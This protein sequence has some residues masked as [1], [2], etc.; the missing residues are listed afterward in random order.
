MSSKFAVV[1]ETCTDIM[2]VNASQHQV[3]YTAYLIDNDIGF[4]NHIV[5]YTTIDATDNSNK[6][7]DA[8]VQGVIDAAS[9]VGSTITAGNVISHQ[10]FRAPQ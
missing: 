7:K 6:V 9:A 5:C 10:F 3:T 8:Y 2:E 4:R 1:C